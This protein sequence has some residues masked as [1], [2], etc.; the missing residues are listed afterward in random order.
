MDRV[1]EPQPIPDEV[2]ATMDPD[3]PLRQAQEALNR[4]RALRLERQRQQHQDGPLV[5]A[6]RAIERVLMPRG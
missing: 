2:L 5:R 4:K 1:T 6:A 3:D